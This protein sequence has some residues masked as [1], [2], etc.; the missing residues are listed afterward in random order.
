MLR[1]ACGLRLLSNHNEKINFSQI[2]SRFAAASIIASTTLANSQ[3]VLADARLN[4]PTAAGTRVN[5]DA[6]S[7]LRY[8]LPF[9]NKEIRKIQE[10]IESAKANLRTRRVNFAKGDVSNFKSL[11][12]RDSGKILGDVP[13][14]NSAEASKSLERLKADISALENAIQTELDAGPGSLQE[15]KALDDAFA[16]QDVISKELSTFEE[17]LVDPA[18]KREIPEEFSKLP[19]LQGRAE[20]EIVIKKADGSDFDVDGTL[21]DQ[22]KMR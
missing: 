10:S 13:K 7:L 14:K 1:E 12:A 15:R 21:F 18:F 16:A 9:E 4:A 5:S 19:A 3:P 17:L 2:F 6:E 8:G 11:L 22:V 20:V